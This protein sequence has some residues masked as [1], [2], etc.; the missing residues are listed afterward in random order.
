[1]RVYLCARECACVH[2]VVI[3][4]VEVAPRID[5]GLE[6][7]VWVGGKTTAPLLVA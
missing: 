6:G 5:W 1:M 2:V 4:M 3:P 7:Q